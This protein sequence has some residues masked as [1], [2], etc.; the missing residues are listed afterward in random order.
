[1]TEEITIRQA[2]AE[3]TSAGRSSQ[4]GITGGARHGAERNPMVSWAAL[5]QEAV[6]KP[7]YIHEAYSRFHSYSLGNQVLALFQCFERGVQ[8]GPL[9]T[10]PKW[11][12]LS[13]HVKK[14]EK[15]LTLCMPITC[16]RTKTVTA[17]DGTEQAE[18][19]AFTHFTYKAHW[20]VLVQTEGA[21]YQPTTLPEWNEQ[22]A[23][24]ALNIRR[25]AFEDLDGNT[26]G[27]A[28]RGRKVAIS[29]IAAQPFKTLFHE[30]A[31]VCLGHTGDGDLSD[32]E[33]TPRDIREV[34]A[35]AVA[36]LCCESLGLP[37]AE[38]SR[39][40]IQSWGQ[41]QAISE[42]SAQRIF[43]AAD[44]ILRAGRTETSTN[45]EIG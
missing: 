17:E 30:L 38:F 23:L 34:E 36:L 7:G 18:E 24:A 19:L 21:E 3:A 2:T 4:Q 39:G 25:E 28:K 14:G 10:F 5:L 26:Q 6:T 37:G 27:Y 45:Q 35:E 1:M 44:Q 15:A 29:P 8:P 13:R 22:T 11:K 12:E 32:S 40:Y 9:A 43:H 31:H 41:G 16:K 42:R 20:F 33:A